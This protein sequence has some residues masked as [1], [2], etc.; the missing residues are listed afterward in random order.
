MTT[1]WSSRAR[2]ALRCA[3]VVPQGEL[4][5]ASPTRVPDDE[6]YELTGR[7]GMPILDGVLLGY[8]STLDIP[9]DEDVPF[10]PSYSLWGTGDENVHLTQR[11]DGTWYTLDVGAQLGW[12]E[13]VELLALR[14]KYRSWIPPVDC[15]ES[16]VRL[17]R[18]HGRHLAQHIGLS[19]VPEIDGAFVDAEIM[20]I[21]SR[22]FCRALSGLER[23]LRG[24]RE[25]GFSAELVAPDARP[26]FV[27]D[28]EGIAR[29]G[30]IAEA[31]HGHD[32]T[33]A[34]ID[35]DVLGPEAVR[36]LTRVAGHTI[37]IIQAQPHGVHRFQLPTPE[38]GSEQV[39][40]YLRRYAVAL[41]PSQLPF[42]AP[43]ALSRVIDEIQRMGRL[44]LRAPSTGQMWLGLWRHQDLPTWAAGATPT[45]FS[46]APGEP[47]V[48]M[49]DWPGYRWGDLDMVC[50]G[51]A[52]E[53]RSYFCDATGAIWLEDGVTGHYDF[54]AGSLL[55]LLEGMAAPAPSTRF[56]NGPRVVLPMRSPGALPGHL[57]ATLTPEGTDPRFCRYVSDSYVVWEM[58]P[59]RGLPVVEVQSQ[60]LAD[61]IPVLDWAASRWGTSKVALANDGDIPAEFV[62]AASELGVHVV[63][64]E[65]GG[66]KPAAFWSDIPN[67]AASTRSG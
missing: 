12:R 65:M 19:A 24:C 50:I 37:E 11:S 44:L 53:D 16:P 27:P 56:R 55:S 58:T 49:I 21:S 34:E 46:V 62:A 9:P 59:T 39:R 4:A 36:Q 22:F 1:P 54:V 13:V 29:H 40:G 41:P 64:G 23:V 51:G 25:A 18:R 30:S 45:R 38:I 6:L 66:W 17:P 28:L 26:N 61:L 63:D 32:A 67:K 5:G 43:A 33:G 57:G 52:V 2:E 48:L 15:H 42:R 8:P 7:R 3:P 20:C 47:S 31:F 14:A 35:I 60:R 10:T